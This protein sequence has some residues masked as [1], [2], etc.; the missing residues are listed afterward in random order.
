MP[1]I[2]VRQSTACGWVLSNLDGP[3]L[4][5]EMTIY[6]KNLKKPKF[7]AIDFTVSM[8]G[9]LTSTASS[10]CPKVV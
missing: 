9:T 2:D 10:V 8:K 5:A 1:D 4:D 7:A 6:V 3:W